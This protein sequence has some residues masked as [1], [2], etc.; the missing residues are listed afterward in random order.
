MTCVGDGGQQHHPD[1]N[2]TATLLVMQ[3]DCP[4][5]CEHPTSQECFDAIVKQYDGPP[6]LRVNFTSRPLD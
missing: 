6:H 2:G 4:P 1:C 5:G 3:E